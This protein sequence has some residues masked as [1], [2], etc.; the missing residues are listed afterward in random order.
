[1]QLGVPD[2]GVGEYFADEVYG[3]L[4][5]KLVSWLLP[6]DDQ[7]GAYHM[8]AGRDVEEKG[9]SPFGSDKDRG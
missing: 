1:M 4:D 8:V 7:H 6:F 2:L 5:L 9:F 3:P